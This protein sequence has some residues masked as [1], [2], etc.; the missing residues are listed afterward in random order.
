MNF[1]SPQVL[2]KNQAMPTQTSNQPIATSL[3]VKVGQ[4]GHFI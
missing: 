2:N 1:I 4:G 3:I